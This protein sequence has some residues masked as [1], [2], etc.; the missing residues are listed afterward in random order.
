MDDV[1]KIL[2]EEPI[3]ETKFNKKLSLKNIFTKKRLIIGGIIIISL[4]IF[5]FMPSCECKVCEVCTCVQEISISDIKSQIITKGYVE[6]NN[7]EL[8]LAPYLG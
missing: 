1:E 2:S 8:K 7:G 5:F 4:I 6:L 3:V